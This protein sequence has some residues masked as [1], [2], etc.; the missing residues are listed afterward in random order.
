MG[1]DYERICEW[2]NLYD[3]YL[4]A[5]RGKRWKNSVAK[6]EAS[7]LEAVAL[8]QRELQTRTYRP[9]GY[10]A[11]YVYEPKRRLIQTNSFKDKIVQHAFCDQVLY[12]ALTKP[13][14]LDNYGSQVG[15]GTHFG[16]NRLR[17]FMREYYRK[18]GFSADGWVLK[19]D[20]RHYF[21]SIRPDVLKKDV[22]KYLHDPDCLALA[23]QIIDSTPDPLGIPI[24]N[25][26]SQIFALLYLNQLDHLC[27]EQLRFRYYGRY[28]DDFYI[29]HSDKLLLRQIL[30]EIEA[31]IKPLGLRLNGKT[32]ILP[33]KNGI[34]FLGFHTYLT[35]TGKVV[36][37]VRAKSIDNMKRK[38]R[39]FRGLVD[40]GKMTLDSVVQSYASWTS[41]IS[42]GNTYHLRQ[43]MDAYFFSYFPELKPSP[44]G[45]TT[46]GP[47]TEQ[48]R[49][50]VEGQ[51]RQPV[52]QPDRLDRGR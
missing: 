43:N 18:N 4:K 32:Q 48:P 46:H 42:H 16:L 25:Q 52:R 2:G 27:K 51:V 38:I 1:K 35:Q 26:S 8:I 3:A 24:G 20:V 10:R 6:V 17:D 30:K 12:D 7:A 39:K 33:L 34:D 28:M 37:K 36:R 50:Q 49:K 9:G 14:I 31:Y 41:H 5:R 19:A 29:I 40:S 11:F 15:K 23:C 13:F 21:Q 45:D 47:K 44:K 22:A